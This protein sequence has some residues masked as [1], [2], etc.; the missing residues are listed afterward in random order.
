MDL[1]GFIMEWKVGDLG[2]SRVQG[3]RRCRYGKHPIISKRKESCYVWQVLYLDSSFSL[4]QT[5]SL[6]SIL[7]RAQS[8]S[9]L[10]TMTWTE[11]TSPDRYPF[12][13]A[14]PHS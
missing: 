10:F 9:S 13:L 3:R 6:E 1:K 7:L 14:F 4:A 12:H 2:G 11:G 8:Q 5:K